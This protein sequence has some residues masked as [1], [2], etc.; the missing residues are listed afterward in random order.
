MLKCLPRQ[1]RIL[2]SRT[3]LL[4]GLFNNPLI[5]AQ[6]TSVFLK[7]EFGIRCVSDK[8]FIVSKARKALDNFAQK[9]LWT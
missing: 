8:F 7:P 1:S 2:F 9:P 4:K 3:L 5:N 6:F